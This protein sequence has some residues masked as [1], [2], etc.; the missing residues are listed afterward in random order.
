MSSMMFNMSD[1]LSQ[2]SYFLD[3]SS[4]PQYYLGINYSFIFTELVGEKRDES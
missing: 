1:I 4:Q 3:Y 2:L